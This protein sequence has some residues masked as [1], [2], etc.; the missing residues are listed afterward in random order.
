MKEYRFDFKDYLNDLAKKTPQLGGGSSV[1]LVFCLGISLIEKSLNFSLDKEKRLKRYLFIFKKI[2]REVF[3][4][5]DLDGKLFLKV[6]KEKERRKFFLE[7]SQN[8]IIKIGKNCQKVF[9]LA[10]KIES[11]IKKSIISDF[12]IGLSFIKVSLK[13]CVLNLEANKRLF[14]LTC[15]YINIFKDYLRK[16]EE[17]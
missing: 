9:L 8:L 4:Y 17:F 10:K 11:K 13:G 2:K 12:Y 14:G 3:P 15:R 7:K 6:L 16:W 5:I 1:S